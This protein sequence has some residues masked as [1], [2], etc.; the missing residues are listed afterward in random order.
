MDALELRGH[1]GWDRTGGIGRMCEITW[2]SRVARALAAERSALKRIP[3][4]LVKDEK[5]TNMAACPALPP[6]SAGNPST[7]SSTCA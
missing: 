7:W 1:P 4:K 6:T 5:K 2:K 3:G